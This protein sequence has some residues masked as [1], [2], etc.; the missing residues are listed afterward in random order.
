MGERRLIG[1]AR[2]EP[3]QRSSAF[4]LTRATFNTGRHLKSKFYQLIAN[5]R[6]LER[7][8]Q[9]RLKRTIQSIHYV[10]ALGNLEWSSDGKTSVRI[11]LSDLKSVT[12]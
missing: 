7:T 10:G 11:P 5:H 8:L 12:K 9:A 4:S 2:P 6:P 3:R 1:A